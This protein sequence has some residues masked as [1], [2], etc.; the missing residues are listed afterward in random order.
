MRHDWKTIVYLASCLAVFPRSFRLLFFYCTLVHSM[1][2]HRG[3]DM[4]ESMLFVCRFSED[5][6]KEI[7]TAGGVPLLTSIANDDENC[8]AEEAHN[9]LLCCLE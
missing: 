9:L 3:S 1:S 5:A 7:I 2:R 8:A 4:I 6:K